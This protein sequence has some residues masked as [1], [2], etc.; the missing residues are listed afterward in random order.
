MEVKLPKKKRQYAQNTNE[1][2]DETLVVSNRNMVIVGANGTGKTR[3]GV[4][5]ERQNLKLVHRISAQKS[6]AMPENVF[7]GSRIE[8]ENTFRFGLSHEKE[9]IL[10]SNKINGRWQGHPEIALLN[11]FENLVKALYSEES[12]I[13]IGFRRNYSQASPME[14]PKTRL[15]TIQEIWERLITHRKLHVKTGNIV[16]EKKSSSQASEPE[17]DACK[18]NASNLS[19]GERVVFYLIGSVLCAIPNALIIID[20]PELHLHKSISNKLWNEIEKTRPD[21]TFV[22]ITHDIDFALS[23]TNAV[24]IWTRGYDGKDWDYEVLAE[25]TPIPETL[26]LEI[27]GSRAPVL[28]IEGD[29]NS[30]DYKLLPHIFP[31]LTIKPLGSC[32]KVFNTTTSFNGKKEFHQVSAYGLIDRDRMTEENIT[33]IATPNIWIANVA[34]IE[35]FL[36]LEGVVKSVAS[37]INRDANTIF[38]QVKNNVIAFFAREIEKQALEHTMAQLDRI[39][40]KTVNMK[41]IKSF[42]ALDKSLQDFVPQSYGKDIFDKTRNAFQDMIDNS[43]YDEILQV[44]NNKGIVSE[45]KVAELCGLSSKNGEYLDFI[46]RMLKHQKDRAAIVKDA[47]IAQIR[48][49]NI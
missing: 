20:E 45:S 4:F 43:K 22:Y 28:F 9:N 10:L 48:N 8:A 49:Y 38:E 21:C 3:L 25:E 2:N 16:V 30:I 32:E 24:K 12:D 14:K 33:H 31:D 35:N 17:D 26:Y 39:F 5:F 6:L 13:S 46:V 40:Q 47:I 41:E 44:F 27:L 42:E 19:D 37:A 23:R 29:L 34:E 15:D 18:Y 11:D 1:H 36:L 7:F